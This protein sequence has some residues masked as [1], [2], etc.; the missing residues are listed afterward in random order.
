SG[1]L[2]QPIR[3]PRSLWGAFAPAA[4]AVTSTNVAFGAI[5]SFG[6][7]IAEGVGWTSSLAAG[8]LVSTML[9]A[10]A[11]AQLLGRPV[12]VRLGL[13]AGCLA[14]AGGWGLL[15]V[16]VESDAASAALAGALV[17]GTGAGLALLCSAAVVSSIAPLDR[18]AEIQA[19]YFAVAFVAVA[20]SSLALGPVVHN[21]SLAAAMT[22]AVIADV[23]LALA[24]TVLV[25][26]HRPTSG[27]QHASPAH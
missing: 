20:I 14:G 21:A 26:V 15:L 17:L 12:P 9:V 23:A 10:V 5:G 3:V 8:G 18:R 27:G 22:V 1:R 13:V 16:A 24:T 4:T 25:V 2:V 6:P 11:A 7:E 19:A